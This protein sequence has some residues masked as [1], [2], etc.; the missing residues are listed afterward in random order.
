LQPITPAF[1][2]GCRPHFPADAARIFQRMPPAF[3]ATIIVTYC[4]N[5]LISDYLLV[6]T[7]FDLF[8]LISGFLAQNPQ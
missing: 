4:F 7:Y 2:S 6:L 3:S 1:S 8:Q 5:S